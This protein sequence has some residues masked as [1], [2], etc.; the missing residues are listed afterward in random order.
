MI[1]LQL[2][3][4]EVDHINTLLLQGYMVREGIDNKELATKIMAQAEPQWI[5]LDDP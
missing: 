1:K 5:R 3:Q 2:T 4:R